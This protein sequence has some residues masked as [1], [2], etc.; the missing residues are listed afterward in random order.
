MIYSYEEYYNMNVQIKQMREEIELLKRDRSQ[1]VSSDKTTPIIGMKNF[2]S[3]F[4]IKEEDQLNKSIGNI[5]AL[6]VES[7]RDNQKGH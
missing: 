5:P 2:N 4:E 1:N 7:I 3:T 6:N